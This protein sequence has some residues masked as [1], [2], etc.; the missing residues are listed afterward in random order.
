MTTVPWY[1]DQTGEY[2]INPTIVKEYTTTENEDGTKTFTIT[3]NDGLVWNNGDPI[4]VEEYVAETLF[5]CSKVAADLGV[6]STA[7][8]S[9]AGGQDALMAPPPPSPVCASSTTTPS[10]PPCRCRK[11]ALLLRDHL[12]PA[13]TPCTSSTSWFGEGIT[14]KDDGEGCYFDGDFTVDGIGAQVDAQ[15]FN[16]TDRVSAGPYNLVEFDKESLQATLTIN[17][18]YPRQLRR[19]EALHRED[20]RG[21]DHHRDLG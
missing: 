7:Y 3:L 14:V 18:N 11:A 21:E 19:P 15:R 12:R 2:L 16:S 6:K 13:L 20:R 5:C 1:P 17:P 4:T 9:Y 8:M 10:P